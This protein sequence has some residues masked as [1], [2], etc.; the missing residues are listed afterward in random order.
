MRTLFYF[1]LH[2]CTTVFLYYRV[3]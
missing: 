1:H 2:T 3:H